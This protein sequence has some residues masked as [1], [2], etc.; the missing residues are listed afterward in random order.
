MNNTC[1][2]CGTVYA[3]TPNDVGR[4]VRCKRCGVALAITT[5]GLIRGPEFPAT[6]AGTGSSG[7]AATSGPATSGGGM[8][9]MSGS[10]PFSDT[11]T[12]QQP[13]GLSSSV[14]SSLASG[15]ATLLFL[16][17]LFLVI[18]FTYM[19]PIGEAAT[20]RAQARVDQLE[21]DQKRELQNLLPP[22]RNF[23]DL[24]EE[25]RRSV[26]DRQRKIR[27]EYERKIEI[28]RLEAEQTRISNI[29]SQWWDRYGQLFGFVL[30]GLGCVGYLRTEQPLVLRIV[31]AVILSFM[32]ML[33]FALG[34]GGCQVPSG[35]KA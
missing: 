30:L 21:L 12:M 26:E 24:R 7:P 1:P 23:A 35:L 17:G 27:Q 18:V 33:M 25:E 31:A 2:A 29:R 14:T 9:E 13:F 4:R 5:D 3:I 15:L 6:L 22:G 20:R 16:L 19:V 34:I 11:L 8:I 28:A 32:L 10:A